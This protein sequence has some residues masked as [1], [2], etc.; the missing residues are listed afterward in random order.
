MTRVLAVIVA[1]ALTANCATGAYNV[2]RDLGADNM[3]PSA[4]G[5]RNG[6]SGAAGAPK[7]ERNGASGAARASEESL[8]EGPEGTA[9]ARRPRAPNQD[10]PGVTAA[11]VKAMTPGARIAVTTTDGK[12]MKGTLMMVQ[13]DAIVVRPRT[14]VPEPAQTIPMAQIATIETEREGGMGRAIAIGAAVGAG[15]AL[16][17]FLALIAALSD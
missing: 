7:G 12:T 17:V 15:A 11:Y 13:D 8:S 4:N 16:G 2:K 14:R 10:P 1:S 6:A 5:E 3:T 9:A